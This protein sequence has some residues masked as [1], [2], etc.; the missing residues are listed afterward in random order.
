MVDIYPP[1]SIITLNINSLH[2]PIKTE[3][4]EVDKNMSTQKLYINVHNN[5]SHNSQKVKTIQVSINCLIG[6]Q[7]VFQPYNRILFSNKRN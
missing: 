1:I 2:V 5:I 6:K 7:N 4:D 3:I